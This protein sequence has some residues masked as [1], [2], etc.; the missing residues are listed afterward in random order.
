MTSQLSRIL[1]LLFITVF[2][3]GA[4]EV[5]YSLLEHFLF[6]RPEAVDSFSA[7]PIGSGKEG[8]V[9]AGTG[10]DSSIILNRNLFGTRLKTETAPPAPAVDVAANLDKS[11]LDIVLVG[12][13]GG[14]GGTQRAF[15][16]D[17]KNRKQDLYSEGDEIKGANIKQILRGKVILEVEGREEF[18][19]MSEAASVRPVVKVPQVPIVPQEPPLMPQPQEP[20]LDQPEVATPSYEAGV[21]E[22]GVGGEPGT[23]EAEQG[24]TF[25]EEAAPESSPEELAPEVVPEAAPE[26]SPEV[27]PEAA[28]RPEGGQPPETRIVRPRIIRPYR[29]S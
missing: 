26:V 10:R 22:S 20:A 17:K 27:Q 3:I 25:P 19:D 12:T 5:G 16:L 6:S 7:T 23:L 2:C 13:I 15:I 28:P 18:L 8:P 29:S 14:S 21:G 4:V 1:P 24:G 11:E 9:P